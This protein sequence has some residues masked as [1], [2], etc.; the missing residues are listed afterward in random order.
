LAKRLAS[1]LLVENALARIANVTTAI[2][3]GKVR[4]LLTSTNRRENLRHLD[5]G[6]LARL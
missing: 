1:V 6:W 4:F 3:G 5:C 2:R